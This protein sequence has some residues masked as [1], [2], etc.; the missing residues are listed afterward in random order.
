M[1]LMEFLR[2]LSRQ[3]NGVVA[4]KT[5]ADRCESPVRLGNATIVGECRVGAF[6]YFNYGCE[7]S[8]AKIGRYCSIGQEV[9]INPGT[10][11]QT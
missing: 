1:G 10:I 6:T 2:S 8:S 9:L 11:R 3:N 5:H 7:V 4:S